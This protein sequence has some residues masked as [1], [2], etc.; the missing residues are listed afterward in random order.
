MD[1]PRYTLGR[2]E[3]KTVIPAGLNGQGVKNSGNPFQMRE[4]SG[5]TIVVPRVAT[6]QLPGCFPKQVE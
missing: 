4:E 3:R 6:Y 2:P 5:N 1:A